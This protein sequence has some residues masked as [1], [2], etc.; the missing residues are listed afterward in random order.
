VK[1]RVP[2]DRWPSRAFAKGKDALWNVVQRV[3]PEAVRVKSGGRVQILR[4]AAL[5]VNG[6]RITTLTNIKYV[7]GLG[8]ASIVLDLLVPSERVTFD[9]VTALCLGAMLE[10]SLSPIAG[11]V[12]RWQRMYIEAVTYESSP[13]AGLVRGQVVLRGGMPEIV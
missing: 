4:S 13:C 6:S 3:F 8:G 1:K 7:L 12:H 5:R 9:P 11:S 10:V 2:I